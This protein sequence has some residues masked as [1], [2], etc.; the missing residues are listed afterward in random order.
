MYIN[1]NVF[2]KKA[3]AGL[4][5]LVAKSKEKDNNVNAGKTAL[6]KG[7]SLKNTLEVDV[8]LAKVTNSDDSLVKNQLPADK[9]K[10]IGNTEKK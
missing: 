2:N 5:N 7:L 6:T 4:N 8:F 10:G 1:K 3:L 9:F